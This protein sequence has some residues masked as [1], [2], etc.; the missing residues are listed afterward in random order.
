MS[1]LNK[2]IQRAEEIFEA[3]GILT[4]STEREPNS[5]EREELWD[6]SRIFVKRIYELDLVDEKM[7]KEERDEYNK[8]AH[9]CVVMLHWNDIYDPPHIEQKA[10]SGRFRRDTLA[11]ALCLFTRISRDYP[12][13]LTLK[14]GW[15]NPHVFE[16]FLMWVAIQM[17]FQ[18]ADNMFQVFNDEIVES[19]TKGKHK[20][21]TSFAKELDTL[22]ARF[23]KWDWFKNTENTDPTKI[24]FIRLYNIFASTHVPYKFALNYISF[25]DDFGGMDF[26][27]NDREMNQSF[28]KK[29]IDLCSFPHYWDIG[30]DVAY[31]AN[32]L[33]WSD[34]DG[35]ESEGEHKRN[36]FF[37]ELYAGDFNA[38][39][40]TPWDIVV[41]SR[42][43]LSDDKDEFNFYYIDDLIKED[44]QH[45]ERRNMRLGEILDNIRAVTI[46]YYSGDTKKTNEFLSTILYIL[47]EIAFADDE[48]HQNE[49]EFINLVQSHWGIDTKIWS[50]EDLSK[51]E[52]SNNSNV[53]S[54]SD[55]PS[56]DDDNETDSFKD[57]E[58]EMSEYLENYPG[59]FYEK[60]YRWD[61]G[62]YA[63]TFP[64]TITPFANV[65]DS[66]SDEESKFDNDGLFR[67]FTEKEV[68]QIV[69]KLEDTKA[70]ISLPFI[71]RILSEKF[72]MRGLK[73]P[74]WFDPFMIAGTDKGGLFYFEQN[75]FYVNHSPNDIP[76]TG[77]EL[78]S[79]VDSFTDLSVVPGYDA[80]A[81][82]YEIDDGVDE[83]ILSSLRIEW[84]NPNSGNSGVANFFQTHG[85]DL[86]C[87]LPIVKA[88]W[89]NWQPTVEQS[90][91]ASSFI[92]PNNWERFDSWDELLAWA[93]DS[94]E[95]SGSDSS[96]DVELQT[97]SAQSD[98]FS[99]DDYINT[100]K[101]EHPN[102]DQD[103]DLLR[104]SVDFL[105]ETVD[106]AD[107]LL[108][109]FSRTGGYSKYAN[110]KL[111]NGKFAQV[112]W[113]KSDRK[114]GKPPRYFVDLY[115]L[116][117]K[118]NY[119]IDSLPNQ[120][121]Q[122]PHAHEFYVVRL[123][124]NDDFEKNKDIL[125]E[126][127]KESLKARQKNKLITKRKN[128]S[129]KQLKLEYL[130]DLQI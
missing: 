5:S 48:L 26:H 10:P 36:M 41:K 84:Y 106:G 32:W 50:E 127:I 3:T 103:E 109:L 104:A 34:D 33:V 28:L 14:R 38:K 129:K 27:S 118:M 116:K 105:Y 63:S 64:L 112:R 49:Y 101:K 90:K 80:Y 40:N 67:V 119:N 82:G 95:E 39:T 12:E 15:M 85:K 11:L 89:D 117:S 4:R 44:H 94:E 92:L 76:P 83:D 114:E 75:G 70:M 124:S 79:H 74:F 30:C 24:V 1:Q 107:G 69:K 52:S 97:S 98:E 58:V 9:Y 126:R 31:L 53:D 17:K 71:Y 16:S 108:E 29:K 21:F 42:S 18:N 86:A 51:I 96:N 73:P 77:M 115:L 54:V 59:I 123:Y 100:Y 8:L 87:T 2:S 20:T 19:W 7:S 6:L 125:A 91:G 66:P 102:E 78:Y 68:N 46:K 35:K 57:S 25:S 130:K 93:N 72:D 47:Q 45:T 81:D 13:Y 62:P 22:E 110:N 37:N 120:A 23:E 128:L 111:K 99:F 61:N 43:I 122:S 56:I 113:G 65:F 121:L 55:E 88:L 60:N